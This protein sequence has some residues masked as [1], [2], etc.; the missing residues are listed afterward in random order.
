M[1]WYLVIQTPD[2]DFSSPFRSRYQG[3]EGLTWPAIEADDLMRR[4]N[5]AMYSD[6][7]TLCRDFALALEYFTSLRS[8][9]VS[10]RLLRC[11]LP[12]AQERGD[13]RFAF[14]GYD[15]GDR[16]GGYSFIYDEILSGR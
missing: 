13:R 1:N 7:D 4:L 16:R 15:F 10:A 11:S 6:E 8:K 12:N 2:R 14:L 3:L 5:N 9:I